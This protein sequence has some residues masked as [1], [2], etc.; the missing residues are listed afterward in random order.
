MDYRRN[1][2]E[3]ICVWKNYMQSVLNKQK[4]I[5]NYMT[6]KEKL[7]FKMIITIFQADEV[8][9]I[10][11]ESTCLN[12][13]EKKQEEECKQKQELV[14]KRKAEVYGKLAVLKKKYMN[15]RER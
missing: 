6:L 14:T 7:I 5:F 11:P 2:V 8:A 4:L 13:E 1:L 15:L 10:I 12:L 9:E 3:Y